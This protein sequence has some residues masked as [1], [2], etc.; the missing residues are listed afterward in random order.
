MAV[1]TYRQLGRPEI[2]IAKLRPALPD[3]DSVELQ[4]SVCLSRLKI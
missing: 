1:T 4:F 3:G 2:L